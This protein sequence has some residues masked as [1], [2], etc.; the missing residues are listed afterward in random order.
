M[1]SNSLP[2]QR[3]PED[4]CRACFRGFVLSRGDFH[5]ADEE[6][7]HR[8]RFPDVRWIDMGTSVSPTNLT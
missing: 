7:S 8:G 6:W 2:E 5:Y 1:P 4:L 3:R